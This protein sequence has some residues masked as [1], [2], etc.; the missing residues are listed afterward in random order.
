MKF[1]SHPLLTGFAAACALSVAGCAG[2]VETTDDSTR[3]E[4]EGPVVET[5][6]EET[7]LDVE[8]DED[9]DVDTP[10]EGDT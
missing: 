2:D 4:A 1:L 7:D 9:V 3:M 5:G 10:L 6:P 8:S